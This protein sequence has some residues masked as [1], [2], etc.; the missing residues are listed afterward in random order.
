MALIGSRPAMRYLPG[1]TAVVGLV[2]PDPLD[3]DDG[4]LEVARHS[5]RR[6]SLPLLLHTRI[7]TDLTVGELVHALMV[8]RRGGLSSLPR[9]R[10]GRTGQG[11]N[12]AVVA[13]AGATVSRCR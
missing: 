7:A 9:S 2:S 13:L 4:L 1:A 10:R 8:R 3:P 11:T 6:H 5:P 12:F